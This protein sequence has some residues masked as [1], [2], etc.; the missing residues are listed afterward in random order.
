MMASLFQDKIALVT[1]S[2]RGIGKAI[3]LH[4]AEL[5]ADIVVNFFRNRAPAEAVVAEIQQMGRRAWLVKADIGEKQGLDILFDAVKDQVGGLDLLIMNAA[6][7][8]NRPVMEQRIKGWD[9]TMNINARAALFAAQRAA[10]L[11]QARGGGAIVNISSPGSTRVLPE[12]VVVGASK[13]ALEALTRYLAVELAEMNIVVNAVSPG[14]VWTDALQ[15]FS[16]M[17]QDEH[18]L[19]KA[20]RLTPAGR[21]VSPEDIARVVAFLCTP[22]AFMIRGQTILV[23]G[24]YTLPIQGVSLNRQG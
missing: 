13:A 7:G 6:S 23:D 22:A 9:W 8:Y 4:F 5:G 19:E 3:A 16:A 10:P 1:G 18:L 20:T 24:G 17:S 14:V 15:H 12:Y 21:L 11:M 2:G